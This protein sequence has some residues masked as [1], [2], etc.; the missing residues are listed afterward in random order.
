V[1]AVPPAVRL[2]AHPRILVSRTDRIGDVVLTLPLCG[3][4]RAELGATVVF[5]GRPYT[6]PVLE[7]APAVD[8]V[9]DWDASASPAA[10][11]ALLAGARADAVLHVFPQV[12]VARAARAARVPVRVGTSRRW[13]HWWT[14][15]VRE[16]LPRRDA[17][18]HEAQLNVRLARAVLPRVDLPLDALAP[19]GGLVPR[20]AVP[21]AV[22]PLLAPDRFSLVVHPRSLGS[23]REWPLARYR[24]LAD[25]LPAD[26]FRVLV[27]GSAAEGASM[28]GWLGAR[29]A[30]VHDLTGR[31][32]LGELVAVL[33]AA[34]GVVAAGTGPVHVAAA[35]GARTLGL[36]PPVRPI[37]PGR[38]APLGPRAEW[39]AAEAPCAACAGEGGRDAAACACM[40]AI[41]VESVRARVE[42]WAAAWAAGRPAG[43]RAAPGPT[44]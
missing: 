44:R 9:L 36:F 38:W 26:R 20:A 14:C 22:A 17:P 13:Y 4:L 3:L 11:R 32:T 12:A 39:L 5:L 40:A 7:A 19:Y 10:Q 33:S 31:L 1:S 29:P 34:G 18:W 25:A 21:A 8:E 16:P 42:A 43:A 28:A 23:G 27:T 2:P 6:R 41:P 37:H 15:T 24:A 35:A 30:H